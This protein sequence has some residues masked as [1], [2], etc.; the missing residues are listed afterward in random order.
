MIVFLL[1]SCCMSRTCWESSVPVSESD[2][3]SLPA[4]CLEQEAVA[5]NN[6]VYK[7]RGML[8]TDSSSCK[9]C[10][11]KK[12]DHNG[13]LFHCDPAVSPVRAHVLLVSINAY[14]GKRTDGRG[15]SQALPYSTTVTGRAPA[16]RMRR[17][18]RVEPS[19]RPRAQRDLCERTRGSTAD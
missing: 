14:N 3:L 18:F 11:K 19:A 7:S 6:K 8:G 5:A 10:A 17:V 9:W 4:V 13:P 1:S 15:V 12:P 2:P 16:A